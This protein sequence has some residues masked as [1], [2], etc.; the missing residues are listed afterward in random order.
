MIDLSSHPVLTTVNTS[1]LPLF[2]SSRN[3]THTYIDTQSL[4]TYVC[5]HLLKLA[6]IETQ[7]H[8][9][10]V[11]HTQSHSQT[12]MCT[13]THTHTHKPSTMHFLTWTSQFIHLWARENL[14]FGIFPY[15]NSNF[16]VQDPCA[17][18]PK[19]FLHQ[20]YMTPPYSFLL[21]KMIRMW[22]KV[23]EICIRLT[24]NLF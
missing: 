18:G 11:T 21:I 14:S 12:H 17:Q 19:P 9:H 4:T 10:M 8:M 3:F 22:F 15:D 5:N 6:C 16:H 2:P 1:E 7:S 24:P 20:Q 13:H 23:S